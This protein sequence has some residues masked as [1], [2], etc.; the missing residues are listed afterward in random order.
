MI[1]KF[2]NFWPDGTTGH[3]DE[4]GLDVGKL[5]LAHLMSKFT[6]RKYQSCNIYS[7]FSE[8]SRFDLLHKL[9]TKFT[10]DRLTTRKIMYG[11]STQRYQ[12]SKD[13]FN[14]WYTP[15]NLRPPLDENFNL[16]LSHDLDHFDGRNVYLPFW[17][18][19]LGIDFDTAEEAQALFLKAR[20]IK[21]ENR[22]GVCAVISNPE[23][24][25]MAFI[26]ELR[27]HLQVDVYGAFGIPIRSKTEVLPKY[28]FNVCF[29]NDSYPGY[30]TEKVFEAWNNG[31]IPIWRGIDGGDFLNKKAIINVGELGFDLA[32]QQVLEI[33]R[34]PARYEEKIN[35]P[36]LQKMFD[37]KDLEN[38]LKVAAQE[39]SA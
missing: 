33:A 37:L 16:F 31:C 6:S 12:F 4:A 5:F 1:T 29:E 36:L 27:K 18:T 3:T 15:E 22:S 11:H 21:A 17:I 26:S 9:R 35:L 2:I 20:N 38:Q 10:G 25:R 32:I 14:V 28:L 13:K 24:I 8:K 7:H 34:S 30:V 19:K 23:P 39:I